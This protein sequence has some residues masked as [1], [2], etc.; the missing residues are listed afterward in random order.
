MNTVTEVMAE[1]K[2]KGSEST[3]RTF[4]RHGVDIPC[5]GVKVGD[6]KPIAKKIKGNQALALELYDTGVYD[7]MYLAGL[8][9]DGSQMSK[10]QLEH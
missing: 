2:K 3:R 6:L 1:L 5:F 8:V 7:A 9:A 10:K 4:E